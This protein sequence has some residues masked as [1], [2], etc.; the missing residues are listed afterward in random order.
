MVQLKLSLVPF[1]LQDFPIFDL[2]QAKVPL[3]NDRKKIT[4]SLVI[5]T[6]SYRIIEIDHISEVYIQLILFI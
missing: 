6:V 1:S 5:N 4:K 2:F 3:H